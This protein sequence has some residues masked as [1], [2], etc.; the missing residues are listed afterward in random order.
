MARA[1]AVAGLSR[2]VAAHLMALTNWTR[3]LLAHSMRGQVRPPGVNAAAGHSAYWALPEAGLAAWMIAECRPPPA[4]LL[5]VVVVVVEEEIR[6]L[7]K[8]ALD[9]P[10]PG[11]HT[12]VMRDSGL[13]LV[14]RF[15][16]VANAHLALSCHDRQQAGAREI[17]QRREHQSQRFGV[18]SGQWHLSY[19]QWQKASPPIGREIVE[20]NSGVRPPLKTS[21]CN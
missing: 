19:R 18:C 11:W 15:L 7:V 3:A 17:G 9:K 10:G 1:G 14:E 5:V 12:R 13:A 8:P 6:M 21:M 20:P 4:S 2:D 16:Q